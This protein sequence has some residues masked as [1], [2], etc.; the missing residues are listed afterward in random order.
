MA[1]TF[2]A[3]VSDCDGVHYVLSNNHVLADEN[4]LP[5]QS[6]IYQPGLLDGGQPKNDAIAK[7]SRFVRLKKTGSNS[8]DAA[9]ARA[10]KPSYLST[11]F[12]PK[13]GN[14]KSGLPADPVERMKV[15]KVG[16]TTGYTEGVI[17]DI[18]ADVAV[19]YEIGTLVFTDQIIIRRSGSPFSASGDSGSL[20][21]DRNS[22]CPVGLLFGGSAAYSLANPLKEVLSRL[23]VS[24][25][26]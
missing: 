8:V 24:V 4:R 23:K 11:E 2:G 16:R 26:V 9:I 20:I 22:R 5:L 1:G 12:L 7:L 3:V 13:I 15:C 25:V 14:L 21:V 10:L 19:N 17:T 18:A 6:R